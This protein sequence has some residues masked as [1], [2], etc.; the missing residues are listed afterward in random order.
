MDGVPGAKLVRA[1]CLLC[2]E[3]SHITRAR[4]SLSEWEDTVQLMIRR[5]APITPDELPA[6]LDYL[7]T[8]Y[9]RPAN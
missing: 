7:A 9:G 3:A 2:H 6:I 5:G 8:H 1:K 4:L